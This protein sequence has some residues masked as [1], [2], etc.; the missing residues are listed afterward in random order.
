MRKKTA[1]KSWKADAN[2]KKSLKKT[3]LAIL[4]LALII[5]LILTGKAVA[6]IANFQQPITKDEFLPVRGHF[7]DGSSNLNLVIKAN[8]TSLVSY[9]PTGKKVLILDL[10]DSLYIPVPGGYGYWRLSSIYGLG[11]ADSQKLGAKLIKSSVASFFGVPI[12]G[13][14]QFKGSIAQKN[15]T[16]IVNILKDGI[17]SY[18]KL[19]PNLQTDLSSLETLKFIWGI[20]K[21]RFDKIDTIDLTQVGVLDKDRL[22]DGTQVYSSD[23]DRIDSISGK[24]AEDK[25]SSEKISIALFNATSIPGLAKIGARIISNLGGN[26]IFSSNLEPRDKSIIY[27][28][29]KSVQETFTLQKVAEV[30][31]SECSSNLKCDIIICEMSKKYD[32]KDKCFTNDLQ[33]IDSRALINIVL[34]SDFNLH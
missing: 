3:K 15:T 31:A 9:D 1:R 24:L 4:V 6:F 23:P 20:S 16:E 7:W 19:S 13:F 28:K 34:G 14:I 8:N 25:I 27:V 17:F 10:P 22:P 26:V 21:V 11:Q 30:F 12:D 2:H 29:E 33:I 18:V 5:L 32:Q